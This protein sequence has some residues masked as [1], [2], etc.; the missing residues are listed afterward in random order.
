[1]L[2]KMN[3]G[4]GLGGLGGAAGMA[5]FFKPQPKEMTFRKYDLEQVRRPVCICMIYIEYVCFN[6]G[7]Y[8]IAREA[9]AEPNAAW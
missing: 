5:D 1:M 9:S 2:K 7:N 8:E 4:G 3:K 6:V